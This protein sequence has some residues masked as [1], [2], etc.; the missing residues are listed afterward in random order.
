MESSQ[1]C[2]PG[3][4]LILNGAPRSGKSTL[5]R[6]IQDRFPG[7]WV[8]IGVDAQ[9]G[10]IG[11]RHR[12]GIGL[13]PGG[14]HPEQEENVKRLYAALYESIAAYS[15]LGIHVVTDVGHHEGYSKPL[16]ILDDC[17]Q[18]L[19]GLPAFFIGIRC[20]LE[21][22]MV[23]RQQSSE[24]YLQ[25]SPQQPFPLPV[26]KWQEE[27][28]DHGTYDLEI[29]TT[30]KSP[31]ENADRISAF[32]KTTRDQPTFFERRLKN[33]QNGLHSAKTNF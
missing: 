32:L 10:M 21:M 3:Q 22:I 11:A 27:V 16:N 4:I 7:L 28:H 33:L 2:Q 9:I 23:R 24:H 26:Q 5:A 1:A 20:S 14:E 15:R 19:R 29:D 18:K 30:D 13:R 31:E 6:A 17:A 8:N 12:P 25:G